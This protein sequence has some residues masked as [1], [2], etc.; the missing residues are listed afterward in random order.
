MSIFVKPQ[1]WAAG[2]LC[3][4][5]DPE[6]WHSER[7]PG[8]TREAKRICLDCPVRAA[9]LDYAL[10]NHEQHGI[11][12]GLSTPARRRL[13]PGRDVSKCVNGHDRAEAGMGADGSCRQCRRDSQHRYDQSRQDERRAKDRERY[14]LRRKRGSA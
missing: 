1:P 2:A 8:S 9:C 4:Q 12:G 5:T 13:T 3:A 10:A 11:W 14:Q 6:L 7:S